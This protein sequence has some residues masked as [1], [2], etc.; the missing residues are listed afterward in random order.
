MLLRDFFSR[1]YKNLPKASLLYKL[2]RMIVEGVLRVGGQLDILLSN[3]R[4]LSSDDLQRYY[5]KSNQLQ[6][7]GLSRMFLYK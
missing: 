2:N 4:P 5:L 1:A 7:P 3:L 6:S